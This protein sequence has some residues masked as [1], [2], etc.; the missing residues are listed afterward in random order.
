MDLYNVSSYKLF[1]INRGDFSL[2]KELQT[3]VKG[4]VSELFGLHFNLLRIY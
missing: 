3:I 4:S 1:Q 2:E